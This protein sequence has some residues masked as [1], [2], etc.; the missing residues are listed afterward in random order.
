M[1]FAYVIYNKSRKKIYIGQT[2]DIEKRLERHNGLKPSKNKSYTKR[3]NGLWK[4]IY[5][6]DL[7]SRKEAVERERQLK[8]AKGREFI[9]SVIPR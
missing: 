4:L 2:I 7:Q 1:F 8:T 9:K 5:K 3:N 6:E